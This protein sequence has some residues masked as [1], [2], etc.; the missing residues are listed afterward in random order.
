MTDKIEFPTGVELPL[1]GGGVT[2]LYEF[3]E[4]FWVGRYRRPGTRVW[5][6]GVR[7]CPDGSWASGTTSEFDI[8]P[9]KRKAW[10]VW[11]SEGGPGVFNN[12]ATAANR[13]AEYGGGTIQEIE[14]P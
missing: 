6:Y 10:V 5:I 9:P 13:A 1:R 2:V 4:G 12:K 3:F 14:E 11:Y 7:W 8:L